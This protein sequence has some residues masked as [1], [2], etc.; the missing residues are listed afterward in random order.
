MK[1]IFKLLCGFLAGFFLCAG[2]FHETPKSPAGLQQAREVAAVQFYPVVKVIDGDTI[3]VI[4]NGQK[5]RVRLLGVNTPETVDPKKPVQCYGPQA[6]AIARQKLSGA[7]VELQS[8]PGQGNTDKYH[9][10]LRYV[11]LADGTDFDEWLIANGY[12]FEYTYD[13]PYEYQTEF[14]DAQA[15]AQVNKLGLWAADTCNGKLKPQ[16]RRS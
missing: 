10:L 3:D 7:S 1:Q 13:K 8:D 4:I 15:K 11:F 14:I 6:S 9:R 5:Q 16:L 12:G 2:F